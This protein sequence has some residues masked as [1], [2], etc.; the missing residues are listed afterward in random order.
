MGTE[1]GKNKMGRRGFLAASAASLFGYSA[2]IKA[3]HVLARPLPTDDN[4]RRLASLRP[5]S[6][7]GS[8]EGEKLMRRADL[9]CDVLVAGGGL[10]GIAAALS[11]A[12][13]GKKTILVQDRSRLGGN[14]SSEIKMHPLGVNPH[15]T[16][17]REGGIIEE[18]KLENAAHN[19]QLAWEMWDFVL[20]DKCV[21]EPNLTL[22]LDSTL[23]RAETDGRKVKAVWVRSD[24]ARNI[25]RIEAEIFVDS[26]G[27]SR[28]AMEA[29]AE[30]MSGRDGSKKFGESLAD[31]DEIGTRQGSTL[32]ITM[33][34][35]DKPVPFTAPSWAKK[36][37]PEL[38]KFRDISGDGLYYGYW[39]VELGGVYDAIRDNEMLRFE[40]LAIVMGVW[41]YM[42]NSGKYEGVENIALETIGMVPGRRDTYR[43][44]GEKI[45]TQHD[46]EGKWRDFDDSIAVG[47]WT[48]DDH[49][50]KGFYASDKRPCRQ[51]WK[52]N[53]YNIPFS[54]TYARDFDNLFMAGRNISCSHVVF[55]S[56]RVMSTCAAVG[57]AVG[58]AAAI[59]VGE[60]VTPAALRANPKLLKRLQQELLRNDQTIIG[61]RNEDPADLARAAKASA[62][63]S[64]WGTSPE[65]VLTGVTLD[66]PKENKNK[67][68]AE[69]SGKPWL[70][71]DWASPKKISQIRLTFEPGWTPLSQSGSNYLL[72]SMVRAPQP[73]LVRDYDIVGILEDGSERK[74]A[75][76]RGNYQKLRAHKFAPATVKGVRF[77]FLATNGDKMVY[78]KEIR[79]EA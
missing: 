23:Y 72:S 58:T 28:L 42:K 12:R 70:R 45:L 41:D 25:Y 20:Y 21:T 48:L 55:C 74:L 62:S 6:D 37:T 69:A 34:K 67:W 16:G 60:R 9:K 47:G 36:M 5:D 30:V 31:Y 26:T 8:A 24:T 68:V 51:A 77:D 54:A 4:S 78:V 59:C 73:K 39:W 38:M 17:W 11:A 57:Q 43:V 44:V 3:P 64:A 1:N 40:L 2:I 19:P 71:L 10:A 53:F 22:M 7:P 50:A 66:G 61:I 76:V 56:T 79:A 52:T 33:R 18:L 46:I 29:G 35:H 27:D 14:S 13:A 63:A 75:E 49:P 32:M 15:V 65:N